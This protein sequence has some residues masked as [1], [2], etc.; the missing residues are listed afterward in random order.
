[1]SMLAEKEEKYNRTIVV[2]QLLMNNIRDEKVIEATTKFNRGLFLEAPLNQI[3]GADSCIAYAKNRYVLDAST[4]A[5]MIE[6]ANFQS[7]DIV[8]LVGAGVG[9]G[10][11]VLSK[12]VNRVIAIEEN[13][14][15]LKKAQATIKKL[16]INN[17]ELYESSVKNISEAHQFNRVFFEGAFAEIP[18]EILQLLNYKTDLTGILRENNLSQIINAKVIDNK[19]VVKYGKHTATPYLA[20]FFPT[21]KFSF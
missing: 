8:L 6:F 15:L 10:S 13:P 7:S 21:E 5:S 14:E 9:Y 17:V 2:N 19:L 12:M 1:M 18:S 20:G 11:S 16:K 4:L 3:A